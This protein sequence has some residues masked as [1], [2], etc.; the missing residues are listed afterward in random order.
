MLLAIVFS[1]IGLGAVLAVVLPLLRRRRQA[2]ALDA[3]DNAAEAAPPSSAIAMGLR[4]VGVAGVVLA[5]GAVGAS[6]WF[7]PP[8]PSGPPPAQSATS[9]GAEGHTDFAASAAKLEQELAKNPD[10]AE[11]WLLL[12]RTEA[13]LKEW[14]K[15]ADAYHRVMTLAPD[16]SPGLASAYGEMLVMAADGMVTPAAHQA[17]DSALQHDRE[18]VPARFYLALAEAQAGNTEQAIER[19]QALAADTPEDS[20]IRSELARRIEE[21]AKE[22]GIAAP[23]LAPGRKLAAAPPDTGRPADAAPGPSAQDVAAAQQMTPEERMT[24]IRGMV[25]KLA[26]KLD[27][28][29]NDAEGWLRLGRAYDVLGEPDKAGDAYKRATALGATPPR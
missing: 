25:G 23:V 8:G 12:A 13:A 7:G 17:F 1:L 19:W 29:P 27:A 11:K 4:V 26:Q 22:A 9:E 18:D 3:A 5:I 16:G 15:S 2:V 28:N 10:D 20:E 6:F 24:M 14:Q 21:A